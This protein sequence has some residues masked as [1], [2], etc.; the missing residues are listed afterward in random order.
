M[1]GVVGA[2]NLLPCIVDGLQHAL[3]DAA[4]TAQGVGVGGV[5]GWIFVMFAVA[6][7]AS[8]SAAEPAVAAV[9]AALASL[10]E[11]VQVDPRSTPA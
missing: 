2:D 5:E 10:G 3:A 6:R 4:N 1:A 8:P 11:A 9:S 7:L